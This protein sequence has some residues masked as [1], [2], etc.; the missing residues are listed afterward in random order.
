ML[1]FRT[2][3]NKQLI[4]RSIYFFEN[5]KLKKQ[6]KNESFQILLVLIGLSIICFNCFNCFN[7]FRRL[8]T[9]MYQGFEGPNY[10]KN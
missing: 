1:Y 4:N 9:L 7:C 6:S 3:K 10:N 8:E 2:F 5:Y